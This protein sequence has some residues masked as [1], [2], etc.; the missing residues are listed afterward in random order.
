MDFFKH[1][2]I[3][4]VRLNNKS[5]WNVDRYII[6]YFYLDDETNKLDIILK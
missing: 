5:T 6:Y 2:T 4:Q 3:S 1:L